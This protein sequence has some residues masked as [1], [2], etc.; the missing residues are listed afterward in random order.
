MIKRPQVYIQVQPGHIIA[1]RVGNG[2]SIRKECAGLTHP[3]TLMGDFESVYKSFTAAI[4]ELCPLGWLFK[5]RV[6]VHLPT[7]FEGGYTNVELRAF[8][9]AATMAGASISFLSTLERP[10]TDQELAEIFSA[11]VQA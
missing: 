8:K 4:K 3:R 6:L 2:R 9:E 1:K 7:S 5:P 11:R 10:H